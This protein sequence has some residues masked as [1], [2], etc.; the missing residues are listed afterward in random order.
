MN[1]NEIF[2]F[3]FSKGEQVGKPLGKADIDVDS[4]IEEGERK[5]ELQ[6]DSKTVS[7]LQHR[8]YIR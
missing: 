4:K 6:V 3:V 5:V 7:N 1:G 2:C 8:W